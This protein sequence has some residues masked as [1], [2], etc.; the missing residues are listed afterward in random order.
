MSDSKEA[1]T[2]ATART[3]TLADVAEHNKNESCWIVIHDK[4]YDVSKFLHEVSFGGFTGL[5]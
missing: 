1:G 4:V 3:Y 5:K 2:D